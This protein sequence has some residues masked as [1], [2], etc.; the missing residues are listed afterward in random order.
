MEMKVL[1]LFVLQLCQFIS[2]EGPHYKGGTVTWKPTNPTSNASLVE[3][4]ITIKHSWTLDRFRCDQNLINTQG[5][6]FDRNAVNAYPTLMCQPNPTFCTNSFFQTIDHITLCTDYNDIVQ[7]SSGSYSEKQNLSR[8]TKIDIA[9][10]GGYWAD[11]ITAI[12]G[13]P[14]GNLDW[15]VGTHIDLTLPIFPINS[16][17]GKFRHRSFLRKISAMIF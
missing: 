8:S 16:S 14:P 5:S 4:Q 12:G 6:Y 1:F 2:I 13:S 7:I 3:I 17:P 11:E 10:T 15:Y 9:W